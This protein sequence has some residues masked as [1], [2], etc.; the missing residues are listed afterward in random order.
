MKDL[1]LTFSLLTLSTIFLEC[2][3]SPF[4]KNNETKNTVQQDPQTVGGMHF[5]TLRG[6]ALWMQWILSHLKS[7]TADWISFCS[8]TGRYGCSCRDSWVW[9]HGLCYTEGQTKWQ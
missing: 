1:S 6:T 7:F 5:L 8:T 3:N 9:F 4:E 2:A